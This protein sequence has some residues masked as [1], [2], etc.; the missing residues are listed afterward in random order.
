MKKSQTTTL[1]AFT[2]SS[3][4]LLAGCQSP[5][6]DHL[7]VDAPNAQLFDGMGDRTRPIT[8]TSPEAQVF[9]DQGMAWMYAFNHDEAIRSFAKAAELDPNA[10]MPW[11]GISV[12]EGPNYN[13]PM[14]TDDRNAASWGALQEALARLD[15]ASDLERA[16]IGAIAERYDKP[17]PE[18]RTHLEEA[19]AA[20]MGELWEQ[21]PDDTLVGA[22]YAESLM[23]QR[24][25]KLY[26]SD[27]QPEQDTP[28][29]VATLERVMAI[30]PGNAGANH[31]YIHAVEPSTNPDRALP[32]ADRLGLQ[33]PKAGHLNH[34]PSHIYIQTGLWD[35][36]IEMNA[37]AMVS[38]GEY[39]ERSPEQ[40]I[41]YMYQVHNAHML[42]FSAMMAGREKEAMDA[43]RAMWE[44]IP[45]EVLLGVAPWV[46]LWMTSVYDVHK[47]FGRWDALLAE[48]GPPEY[49]P[50]TT[51]VWHAHRAIAYA[52]KKDLK[53]A[54][55]E[56]ALFEESC[57]AMPEDSVWG[58][59]PTYKI[60]DVSRNF[61]AGE[62]ALQQ[63]NWDEAAEWLE[64]GAAIED[65]LGYGEPPQ[66]LQPIRHTLGVVY[67]KAEKFED[68]ERV[69]R[70]DLSH[71]RHNGWSLYG[72]A[73]AL[74]GQGRDSEA[75]EIMKQ[76]E[77]AF[78]KA[79][80]MHKTS[81]LCV[82]E[83]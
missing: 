14:M 59:D 51:A 69:Y 70:D 3:V 50:I 47:R 15:G 13:D 72:L 63:D 60:L 61:I 82:P 73:R 58:A 38:D 27:R 76:Y 34:M 5:K 77:A 19:F 43:A 83:A 46:D 53:N 8:T 12:C 35:K 28:E 1:A 44:T 16:L 74:E 54:K 26:T 57:A 23:V 52:A 49:L 7:A 22:L 79:D 56:Q 67:L 25:W 4:V 65:V 41:Q 64:A 31:L 29:I 20:A 9:F 30:D 2:I 40:G 39:I 68:A 55:I 37:L 75:A 66:W 36:S 10:A 62:I 78:E 24:P 17:F 18:S 21:N 6:T 71:W 33:I 81:C 80:A 48:P 45:E 11:W 42:A 32:A